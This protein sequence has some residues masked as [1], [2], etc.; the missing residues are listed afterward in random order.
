LRAV[1]KYKYGLF[2]R[3]LYRSSENF[4]D[5][6]SKQLFTIKSNSVER[7]THLVFPVHRLIHKDKEKL[8][9]CYFFIVN[10]QINSISVFEKCE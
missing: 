9:T 6:K 5:L 3:L 1:R 10:E 4:S 8:R 7:L 2:V